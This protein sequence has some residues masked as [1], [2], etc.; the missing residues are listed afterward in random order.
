M[1]IEDKHTVN[2]ENHVLDWGLEDD[3]EYD[4][5]ILHINKE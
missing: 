5:K 4:L 1:K 2:K 3:K